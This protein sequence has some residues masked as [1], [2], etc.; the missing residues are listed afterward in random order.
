MKSGSAN[1][2]QRLRLVMAGLAMLVAMWAAADLH[3]HQS[4]LHA[5]I[6][7]SICALE[8]AVSGGCAPAHV[9]TPEPA[10]ATA[11]EA[12]PLPRLL[13]AAASRSTSIRA[14]PTA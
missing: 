1:L 14:P 5:P 13:A 8:H 4:G 9:W 6:S 12:L 10:L 2:L 7:C 3:H 11:V